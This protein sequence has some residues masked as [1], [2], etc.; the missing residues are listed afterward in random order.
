M[1]CSAKDDGAIDDE[2]YLKLGVYEE[3][4]N[5]YQKD[6]GQT[7]QSNNDRNDG[8]IDCSASSIF[9]LVPHRDK[10]M[11]TENK[12]IGGAKNNESYNY[13]GKGSKGHS[14]ELD[15]ITRLLERPLPV[16]VVLPPTAEENSRC[17]GKI[18]I[19]LIIIIKL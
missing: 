8:D 12:E 10:V 1:D 15:D 13:N 3:K 4:S 6:T 9:Q 14:N 16:K 11:E 17:K 7:V 19:K 5:D 2:Y 18:I